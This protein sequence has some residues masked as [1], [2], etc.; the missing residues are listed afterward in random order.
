MVNESLQKFYV[1]MLLLAGCLF[2]IDGCGGSDLSSRTE[3]VTIH[4]ET[5][6]LELA[7]DDAS[8]EKGLMHRTEIPDRGGM[9]F[10]FPDSKVR[11]QEFWMGNCPIDMDIIYLDGM[12]GVTATHH[13]KAQ[14]PQQSDESDDQYSQRMPRYSSGYPA[15][16]AIELKAGTLDRLK[17]GFDDRIALDLVNLKALA[18]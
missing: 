7:A 5:F 9:L 3:R 1:P 18:R 14:P 2:C 13:M 6:T 16:F 17:I 10:V 11:V 15:Q 8:R 12:G 4:G